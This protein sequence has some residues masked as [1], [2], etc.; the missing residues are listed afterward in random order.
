M[1]FNKETF[2]IIGAG[3]GIFSAIAIVAD[4]VYNGIKYFSAKK[5]EKTI[6][7][8]KEMVSDKE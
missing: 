3:A 6:E 5:A 7:E 8:A 2:C 4:S 1:E